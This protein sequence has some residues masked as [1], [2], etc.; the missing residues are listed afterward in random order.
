M[1]ALSAS[2]PAFASDSL[3]GPP[4]LC[5]TRLATIVIHVDDPGFRC[6]ALRDLVGVVGGRQA[7]PDVKELAHAVLVG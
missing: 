7:R 1:P 4:R 5:T 3:T 2:V 6:D